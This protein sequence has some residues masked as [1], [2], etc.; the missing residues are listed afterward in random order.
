MNVHIFR[1]C[2]CARDVNYVNDPKFYGSLYNC[3]R[4]QLIKSLEEMHWDVNFMS[5][6]HFHINLAVQA[7]KDHTINGSL[8]AQVR[9]PNRSAMRWNAEQIDPLSNRW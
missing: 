4:L 6:L 3:N 7:N 5:R 1:W 8:A 9:R 2:W